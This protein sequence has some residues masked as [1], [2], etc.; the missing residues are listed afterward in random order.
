M[1]YAYSINSG[2]ISADTSDVLTT[3]ENEYKTALNA[4][5]LNTKASTTQG[6][7]IAGEVLSRQ[8]IAKNNAEMANVVNPDYSYGVFLDAICALLGESRG[9]DSATS[10]TLVSF[11]GSSV[12]NDVV[13]P[14]GSRLKTDAGDIF[15][16]STSITIPKGVT[17]TTTGTIISQTDGA[18]PAAVGSLTIV[19]GTIGFASAAITSSS[20]VTLGT[21][22]MTDAQLKASRN[23]RLYAQGLGSVGAIRAH[24]LGVDNV[25]SVNVIENISGQF[26]TAV[27]GVTFTKNYGVYVCVYGAATDADIGAAL[28]AAHGG[29]PFDMGA[30]GQG[31]QTTVA[32]T[33]PYSGVSYTIGFVR[34]VEKTAYVKYTVKRGSSN[35]T[36]AA[37]IEA[38]VNYAN[39]NLSGE[40]GLVVGSDVSAYEFAGAVSSAYPG[41]FISKVEVAI[42]D[43]GADA[44]AESDYSDIAA[45]NPWEVAIASSGTISVSFV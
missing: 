29:S 33:D 30:T 16:T 42:T 34:A 20:V 23:R 21:T 14:S 2:I 39:G 36:S 10:V 41:L 15:L 12:D 38:A 4:P 32:V 25:T 35:A 3:V 17:N 31:T 19:D 40:D 22:A 8:G 5:N 37:I 18:I 1:S 9:T 6:T 26:A 24:V 43:A 45:I 28:W 27:N 13:I 11:V 44:P 7:L